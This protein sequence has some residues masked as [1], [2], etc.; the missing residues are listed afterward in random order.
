[1]AKRLLERSKFGRL[2]AD[3][4]ALRN[5][6]PALLRKADTIDLVRSLEAIVGVTE[7]M[8]ARFAAQRQEVAMDVL[9]G[10]QKGDRRA[11]VAYLKNAKNPITQDI[12]AHIIEILSG[13]Q[14][15]ANRPPASA[16]AQ[17]HRAI[18]LF[19]AGRV[20]SGESYAKAKRGAQE[21][22]RCSDKLVENAC[23]KHGEMVATVVGAIT[24]VRKKSPILNEIMRRGEPEHCERAQELLDRYA[25]ATDEMAEFV[26][27]NDNIPK[28][29]APFLSGK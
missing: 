12:R 22:F 25:V 21:E 23:D 14:R 20:F 9:R 4:I 5:A 19:V 17:R 8:S 7:T 15:S 3:Y 6:D 16:T 29:A 11:L 27:E 13:K 1:M 26:D 10:A 24:L 2:L 28:I 18:A